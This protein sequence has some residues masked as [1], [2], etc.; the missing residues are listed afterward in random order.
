MHIKQFLPREAMLCRRRVSVCLSVT[1]Q[2]CIKTAKR[3][4]TQT[5]PHDSPMTLVFHIVLYTL[6]TSPVEEVLIDARTVVL[7]ACGPRSSQIT[8][9]T[10]YFLR[11]P[12]DSIT[13][14]I[15]QTR[16]LTGFKTRCWVWLT[17]Q[18]VRVSKLRPAYFNYR[19]NYNKNN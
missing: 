6:T 12:V 16:I 19:Y 8:L 3:R 4:I 10:S 17:I 13:A 5:T 14:F 2:Y 11:I 15:V 18:R 9:L 1:L 7:S